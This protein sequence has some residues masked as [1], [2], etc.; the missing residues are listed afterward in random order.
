M[1]QEQFEQLKP[2]DQIARDSENLTYIVTSVECRYTEVIVHAVRV[3]RT[4]KFEQ[5]ERVEDS[6]GRHTKPREYDD[7]TR[8]D[9][10]GVGR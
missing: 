3:I 8:D 5:W 9:Y 4:K 2:G 10:I 7:G 6:A 1:T